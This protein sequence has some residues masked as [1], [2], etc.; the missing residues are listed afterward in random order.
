MRWPNDSFRFRFPACHAFENATKIGGW[1][2][3]WKVSS[4]TKAIGQV[5]ALTR[6]KTSY[7]ASGKTR[8]L[9]KMLH[10]HVQHTHTHKCKCFLTIYLCC[11]KDMT[12]HIWLVESCDGSV[13]SLLRWWGVRMCN[14]AC[15]AI[16]MAKLRRYVRYEFCSGSIFFLISR[17][18]CEKFRGKAVKSWCSF[19]YITNFDKINT[20]L[21]VWFFNASYRVAREFQKFLTK[22]RICLPENIWHIL[23]I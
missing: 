9:L 5:D 3:G 11:V 23:Y 16:L 18:H 13:C 14:T 8:F 10:A 7:T 21:I 15:S 17:L 6:G 22:K 19:V 12:H 4:H 20:N 2:A 1:V